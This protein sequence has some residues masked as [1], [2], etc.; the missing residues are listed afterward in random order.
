MHWHR[1]ASLSIELG[2]DTPHA[3][4]DVLGR[5]AQAG[6]TVGGNAKSGNTLHVLTADVAAHAA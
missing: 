6:I 2:A 3:I 1:P 4:G 5:L